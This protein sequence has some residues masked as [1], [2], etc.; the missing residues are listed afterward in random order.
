MRGMYRMIYLSSVAGHLDD[1]GLRSILET[2]RRNN[3]RDGITGL[4]AH[5]DGDFLQILE[6]PRPEVEVC[7]ARISLDPRHRQVI[8]VTQ[9]DVADR[10]FPGWSMG[11]AD[12]GTFANTSAEGVTRLSDVRDGL[13]GIAEQDRR[14]AIMLRTFFNSHRDLEVGP[15]RPTG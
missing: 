10:L 15:L 13:E 12:P 11:L 5:H 6:G 14:A 8:T 7:F 4:L 9:A 2:S 1:A 3:T